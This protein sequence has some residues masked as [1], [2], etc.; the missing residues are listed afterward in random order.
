MP[1]RLFTLMLLVLWVPI[2]VAIAQSAANPIA[3][4]VRM[5]DAN[6]RILIQTVWV[7][8]PVEAVWNA[9]ATA[10]GWMGWAAPLAEV[11]LRIGGT[12]LTAYSGEIG[13]PETNTLHIINYVPRELLTLKADIS[14]NWPEVL[15]QDADNLS[16]V[17][18]FDEIEV[19]QTLI[20]SY[21]MGYSDSS[22]YEQLMQFF[23]QANEGLYAGLKRYVEDGEPV[24]WNP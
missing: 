11:D 3:S 18:L 17:I 2:S 15:K 22:E 8:A 9:Y 10:E 19:G 13:G 4:E 6:E 5:T 20:T 24:D 21:G 1:F 23:I 12:I 14:R 7:D 16:N